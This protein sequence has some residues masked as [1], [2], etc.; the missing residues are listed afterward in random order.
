MRRETL[1]A[2][3]QIETLTAADW[4]AIHGRAKADN[5]G[6]SA[7]EEAWM[8]AKIG[9]AAGI[10]A[11][12]RAAACGASTLAAAAVAGAVA[13]IEAGDLITRE[14]YASLT[15][16]VANALAVPPGR[17]STPVRAPSESAA[18]GTRTPDRGTGAASIRHGKLL[19]RALV[20]SIQDRINGACPLKRAS[21]RSGNTPKFGNLRRML[22]GTLS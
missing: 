19:P 2:I 1:R 7:W 17:T 20:L 3:Q 18:I 12:N 8:A 6:G 9:L 4:D 11:Q 22:G 21:R 14:H 10:A 5:V 13:A 16:P 15:D